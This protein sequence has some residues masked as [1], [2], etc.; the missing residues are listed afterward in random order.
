MKKI[1][2]TLALSAFALFLCH[3]QQQTLVENTWY[4]SELNIDGVVHYPPYN[5]E[6]NGVEL[7]IMQEKQE[8]CYTFGTNICH[9]MYCSSCNITDTQ[10]TLGDIVIT[11][12]EYCENEDNIAFSGL[13]ESHFTTHSAG[14][15]FH[16]TIEANGDMQTLTITNKLGNTIT[17]NNQPSDLSHQQVLVNNTWYLTE[18]NIDG[19]VHPTPTNDEVNEVVLNITKIENQGINNYQFTTNICHLLFC[20]TRS[21][22]GNQIMFEDMTATTLDNCMN[23]DNIAFGG[24][25][26][27]FYMI[28][29]TETAFSYSI[30]S[31]QASVTMLT[32]TNKYGNTAKY[33][34]QTL[35]TNEIPGQQM[36]IYPNPVSN[37]MTIR[38]AENNEDIQVKIFNL[39]G[40]LMMDMAGNN[41][42]REFD[43]SKLKTG[44]YFVFVS[45][46]S[47]KSLFSD[48]IIKK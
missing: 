34:N 31:K 16:Y 19:V 11:T 47:G 3:A 40:Q 21:I 48:K 38:T 44:T 8:G 12:M 20:N 37:T 14:E 39:Q 45:N 33:T 15:P 27:S 22:T 9:G 36:G 35:S 43:L 42:K 7:Q 26:T 32:I 6:I 25:Y 29:G 13:Y 10:F 30:D 1:I 4:V 5:N 2:L 24:Q 41:E 17:Y 18:L 46:K 23:Q 28:S